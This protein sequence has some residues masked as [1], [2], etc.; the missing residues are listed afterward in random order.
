MKD[1]TIYLC[2][3]EEVLSIGKDLGVSEDYLLKLYFP[4]LYITHEVKSLEDLLKNRDS[5]I[6]KDVEYNNTNKIELY[7]D[8][9]DLL[10]NLYYK[11]LVEKKQLDYVLS[12][13]NK[14]QLTIHPLTKITLPLELLFKFVHSSDDIPLVK[15]NPGKGQENVYRL[16]TSERESEN[17]KK[18]PQLYEE[19][20]FKKTKIL[21]LISQIDNRKKVTYAIREIIDGEEIYIFCGFLE[22]GDIELQIDLKDNYK[23]V[24]YIN[25]LIKEKLNSLILVNINKVLEQEVVIVTIY[26]KT[27]TMNI[28]K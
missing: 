18:I 26:M 14:I 3:A 10:Y 16:F 11:S 23:S 15:Y 6:R 8:S 28:L 7:N 25:T 12:G 4:E 21:K 1:N 13:I 24:E 22:N 5:L 19:H 9:I 17:G 27:Y 20:K 2:T